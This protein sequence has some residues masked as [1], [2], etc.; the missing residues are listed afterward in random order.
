MQKIVQNKSL[1]DYEEIIYSK[2]NN[3][4]EIIES[5]EMNLKESN[6]ILKDKVNL[7]EIKDHEVKNIIFI[8]FK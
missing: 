2:S 5:L 8:L 7:L 3:D 4:N 1:Q 6:K